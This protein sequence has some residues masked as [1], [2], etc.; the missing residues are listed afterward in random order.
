[1]YSQIAYG[2][3]VC[4]NE[5]IFGKVLHRTQSTLRRNVECGVCSAVPCCAM[6]CI[7]LYFVDA[8]SLSSYTHCFT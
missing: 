1:M 8:L 4:M 6:L 3:L 5:T 7:V 2:E